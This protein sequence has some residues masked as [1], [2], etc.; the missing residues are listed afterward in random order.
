L[1]E[2]FYLRGEKFIEAVA[3]MEIE[4]S[5]LGY[6]ALV[7]DFCVTERRQTWYL[8]GSAA[9]T[10]VISSVCRTSIFTEFR[11]LMVARHPLSRRYVG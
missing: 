11:K 2:E 7:T 4:S 10:A 9:A 6:S 1:R 5:Y 3:A 8:A